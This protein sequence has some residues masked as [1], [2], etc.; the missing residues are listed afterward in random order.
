MSIYS[1]TL[2]HIRG[3]CGKKWV[4]LNGYSICGNNELC[5]TCNEKI[6]LLKS[7][8]QE[9]EKEIRTSK[10]DLKTICHPDGTKLNQKEKFHAVSIELF[11]IEQIIKNLFGEDDTLNKEI[12]HSEGGKRNG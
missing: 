10:I 5:V 1:N 8:A 12:K 6:N 4:H 2:K 7:F 11:L 9:I 3:G